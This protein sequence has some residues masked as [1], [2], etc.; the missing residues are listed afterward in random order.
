MNTLYVTEHY[1]PQLIDYARGLEPRFPLDEEDLALLD[2]VT[3][4]KTDAQIG[5]DPSWHPGMWQHTKI[6]TLWVDT[7]RPIP[8]KLS[9]L[10]LE[11]A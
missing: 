5:L 11:N 4:P 8:S 7:D 9:H 6:D 1:A 3:D 10:V 2:F